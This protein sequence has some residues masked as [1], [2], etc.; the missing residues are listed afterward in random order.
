MEN[1]RHHKIHKTHI[2]TL[3]GF[4]KKTHIDHG[5]IEEGQRGVPPGRE[6]GRGRSHRRLPPK[7]STARKPGKPKR[8]DRQM[9]EAGGRVALRPRL[10]RVR[11]LAE[12]LPH[13][14]VRFVCLTCLSS[15]FDC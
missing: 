12:I 3:F 7:K 9:A 5:R 1:V 15:R 14:W 13:G 8:E 4:E 2:E 11:R 6:P 10:V